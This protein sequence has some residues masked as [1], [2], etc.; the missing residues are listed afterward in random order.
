MNIKFRRKTYKVNKEKLTY[1]LSRLSN[2]NLDNCPE[3]ELLKLFGK[4]K[5]Y[6]EV[7]LEN[8]NKI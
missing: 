3:D 4:Y 2:Q 5:L 6:S 7:F 1:V 8:I